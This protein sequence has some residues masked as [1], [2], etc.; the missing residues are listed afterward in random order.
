MSNFTR[1]ITATILILLG[2]AVLYTHA[3]KKGQRAAQPEPVTNQP[4]CIWPLDLSRPQTTKSVLSLSNSLVQESRQ[5][6]LYIESLDHRIQCLQIRVSNALTKV[7]LLQEENARLRYELLRA[8]LNNPAT[9]KTP[10]TST[11]PFS[12]TAPSWP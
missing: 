6:A 5:M 1:N 12:K 3:Y 2:L 4:P 8:L 11:R 7:D 10:C 9:N